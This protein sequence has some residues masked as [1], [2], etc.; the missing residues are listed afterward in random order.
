MEAFGRDV[1][2][3]EESEKCLGVGL[4]IKERGIGP[5]EKNKGVRDTV[6]G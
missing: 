1:A 6:N 2:C 5:R 4:R 3:L